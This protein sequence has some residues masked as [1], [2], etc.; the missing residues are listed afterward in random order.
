MACRNN[1]TCREQ[2]PGYYHYPQPGQRKIRTSHSALYT[3]HSALYRIELL[4]LYGKTV[5]RVYS[6][7]SI[8][9]EITLDAGYLPQG[10]YLIRLTA[11]GTVYSRKLVIVEK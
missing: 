11:G 3:S 7:P 4:D 9:E 6:G 5:A 2:H 1:G 8:P 10:G